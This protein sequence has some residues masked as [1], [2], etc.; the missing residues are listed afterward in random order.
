MSKKDT[1]W[2]DRT[3]VPKGSH[4]FKLTTNGS[5]KCIQLTCTFT[6]LAEPER[7]HDN[8]CLCK[9]KTRCF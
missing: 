1:E 6:D 3:G 7:I 8:Y 2:N 5:N 9:L 4:N